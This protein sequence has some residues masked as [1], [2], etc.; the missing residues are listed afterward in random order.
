MLIGELRLS[1]PEV[2][3]GDIFGCFR[4]IR[5]GIII[6]S[7]QGND[8]YE[9]VGSGI[10]LEESEKHDDWVE[11]VDPSMMTNI[12]SLK[13]TRQRKKKGSHSSARSCPKTKDINFV[14][15]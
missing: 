10:P 13:K 15:T 7:T 4:T 11:S 1:T 12:S 6:N 5:Q 2:S 9:Q 8:V 14:W 3:I